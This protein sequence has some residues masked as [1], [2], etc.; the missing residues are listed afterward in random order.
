MRMLLVPS[1]PPRLVHEGTLCQEC[2]KAEAKVLYNG[3]FLVCMPC[4]DA[5]A[6]EAAAKRAKAAAG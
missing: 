5:W 6:A 1:N 2:R 3:A 4:A